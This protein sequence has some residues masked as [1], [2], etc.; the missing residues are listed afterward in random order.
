MKLINDLES[1]K[2]VPNKFQLQLISVHLVII[3]QALRL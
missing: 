1:A 2:Y 3:C